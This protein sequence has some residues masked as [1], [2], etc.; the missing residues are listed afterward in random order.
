MKTIILYAP[1]A[2]I[3]TL[4]EAVT[5]YVEA[6]YPAGGSECAQSARE[7]LLSTVLTL[8]NE[9]DNDN[10]SVS[11]SRRIKAHLK[12][13]LEYYPQTQAERRQ[14]AEHEASQLLKCLQ[15]DIISQQEW[16]A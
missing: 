10:R 11:I 6:A 15:G 16:D 5:A 2:A 13:A 8:R 12:S 1:P 7:A 3:Q 14:L 9:Y 4:A